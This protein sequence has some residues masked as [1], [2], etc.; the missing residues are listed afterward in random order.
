M[1]TFSKPD[2]RETMEQQIHSLRKLQDR[3]RYPLE[4]PE[5]AI[6]HGGANVYGYL[7][8]KNKIVTGSDSSFPPEKLELLNCSK[9]SRYTDGG[10]E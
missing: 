9:G 3:D 8:F 10:S 7:Q 1:Q 6:V 5:N 4:D 2:Q